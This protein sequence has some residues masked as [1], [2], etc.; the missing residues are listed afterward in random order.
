MRVVS[1]RKSGM[2]NQ[3]VTVPGGGEG[4]GK[5]EA[6]QPII[7]RS[8]QTKH[9]KPIFLPLLFVRSRGCTTRTTSLSNDCLTQLNRTTTMTSKQDP[10][11]VAEFHKEL[12][13]LFD[14]R[15]ASASK[16]DR[17]TKLAFKSAKVT[18]PHHSYTTPQ[19]SL[20]I[21]HSC[22]MVGSL[23]SSNP[24]LNSHCPVFLIV[25]QERRLSS[26]KVYNSL[27][28]RVQ[29]DWSVR[30]GFYLP[31]V[32]ICQDKVLIWFILRI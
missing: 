6:T 11:E 31:D 4:G 5:T 21:H 28:P 9:H 22:Y 32:A 27:C 16:I 20:S 3:V 15:T 1:E 23:S 8:A 12:Y 29:T 26:G 2:N 30:V 24:A 14:S 7:Y 13:S 17:L 10:P 19:L 25:L 18:V